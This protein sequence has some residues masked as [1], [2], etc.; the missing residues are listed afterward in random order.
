MNLSKHLK[1]NTRKKFTSIYDVFPSDSADH[2]QSI[3]ENII[4][5]KFYILKNFPGSYS[6]Y[7]AKVVLLGMWC[8]SKLESFCSSK[9]ADQLILLM[10]LNQLSTTEIFSTVVALSFPA[11]DISL[12]HKTLK[13]N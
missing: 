11:F 6:L 1:S 5:N 12:E 10:A 9:P 8:I 13:L 7:Y 4:I 3:L 2:N